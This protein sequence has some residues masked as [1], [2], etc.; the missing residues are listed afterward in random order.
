VTVPMTE[1]QLQQAV[2]DLAR[3][4]GYRAYH[5]FDSR[6]SDAGFPDLVLARGDWL[7]FVE[8]KRDGKH[9]TEHQERWLQALDDTAALVFVWRPVDWH[10]GTCEAVL[11]DPASAFNGDL[12]GCRR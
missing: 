8:L 5:T 10:A 3:H 7:L 11:K 1:K 6:R 9:P 4:L 2:L 12:Y